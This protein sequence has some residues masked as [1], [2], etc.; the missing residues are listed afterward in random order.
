MAD[1]QRLTHA[2]EFHVSP[3]MGLEMNYRW[4]LTAP[5]DRLTVA[6]ENLTPHG[7]LFTA[8]LALRRREL[9]RW[10]LTQM[11]LRAKDRLSGGFADAPADEDL[12]DRQRT[13]WE[14]YSEGRL[15]ALGFPVRVQRRRYTFRLYGGFND[16]ADAAFERLWAGEP[17]D[18]SGLD[19]LSGEL[20][21]ADARPERKKSLRKESLRA[22]AAS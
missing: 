1:R 4:R 12:D 19:A 11:L 14:A 18:W 17:I 15:V 21:A 5:G 22:A 16:A 8:G 7:R 2:K 3:F 9:T 6:V 10:N 20:R 13:L